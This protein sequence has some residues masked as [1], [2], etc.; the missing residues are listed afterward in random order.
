MVN[1]LNGWELP[2]DDL[3]GSFDSSFKCH[4]VGSRRV[5][6]IAWLRR[7]LKISQKT[8]ITQC[9]HSLGVCPRMSSGPG[10]CGVSPS[11]STLTFLTMKVDVWL[12]W[13]IESSAGGGGIFTFS[14]EQRKK[15]IELVS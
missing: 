12:C 9:A 6:T 2:C 11:R 10:I 3:L 13:S 7:R 14:N 4:T 1:V 5:Q 15:S 8:S